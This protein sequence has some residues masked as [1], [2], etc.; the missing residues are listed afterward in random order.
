MRLPQL[1]ILNNDEGWIVLI[2]SLMV[3]AGAFC[4]AIL[5]SR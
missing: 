5:F 2:S 1:R 4:L 3:L